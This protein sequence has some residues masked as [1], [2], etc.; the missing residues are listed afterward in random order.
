MA[1]TGPDCSKAVY[2]QVT[3]AFPGG[4]IIEEAP[5]D[6]A[7]ALSLVAQYPPGGVAYAVSIRVLD[8][9]GISINCCPDGF[10]YDAVGH[11]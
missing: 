8:A 2:G 5:Q 3:M 10:S 1:L 4:N 11:T 7:G 9:N 6:I